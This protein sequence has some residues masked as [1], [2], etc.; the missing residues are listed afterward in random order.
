MNAIKLYVSTAR[1]VLEN[2]QY[3]YTVCKELN[4]TFPNLEQSLTCTVCRNILAEPYSP[5][6]TSCQH[7]VCKSCIGGTKKLKP[8]CSW[9]KDYTKYVKNTQLQCLLLCYKGLCQYIKCSSL[10]TQLTDL[11]PI[12]ENE[13]DLQNI[14]EKGTELPSPKTKT[15]LSSNNAVPA[16]TAEAKDVKPPPTDNHCRQK[17]YRNVLK[18]ITLV[19]IAKVKPEQMCPESSSLSLSPRHNRLSSANARGNSPRVLRNVADDSRKKPS[20]NE[21]SDSSGCDGADGK[22]QY[23]VTFTGTK[24]K[25]ILKRTGS[26]RRDLKRD[27]ITKQPTEQLPI[28][29]SLR[30]PDQNIQVRRIPNPEGICLL[31]FKQ[32]TRA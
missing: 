22:S 2:D 14:I 7:H 15:E 17:T 28:T 11:C 16:S 13:K 25:L 24:S 10:L 30:S 31:E 18:D 9:C 20:L 29:Y 3:D 32:N 4:N 8:S 6:E 5:T 19:D 23:S 1:L 12:F 21:C 26:S 27:P